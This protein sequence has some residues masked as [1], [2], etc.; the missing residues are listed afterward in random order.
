MISDTTTVYTK[1][2][3]QSQDFADELNIYT[4]S[5]NEK[6]KNDE[7]FVSLSRWKYNIGNYPTYE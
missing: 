3:M 2:H 6:H 4:S 1:E 7:D 5:Y